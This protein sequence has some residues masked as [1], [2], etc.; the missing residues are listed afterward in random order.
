MFNI[1]A[2]GPWIGGAVVAPWLGYAV[3]LPIV[4]HAIVCIIGA[5]IG[6]AI[7]GWIVGEIKAR[8]GAHEVILTIMLNYVMY[9]FLAFLLSSRGLMQAPG[10][11][12][13]VAPNIK[14][15]AFLPHVGGPPPQVGVGFL[16]ALA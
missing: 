7:I 10:Q 2:A 6:G 14:A 1:A 15:N 12:N 11:T 8:T 5:S 16:I 9:N 13:A 3:H 4:L